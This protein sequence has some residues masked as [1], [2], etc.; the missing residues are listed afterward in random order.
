[1]IKGGSHI[2][3]TETNDVTHEIIKYVGLGD[4][5]RIK[6]FVEAGADLNIPWVDSRTPLHMVKVFVFFFFF[7]F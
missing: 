1:L 3:E 5:G 4:L 6:M 7:L 2:S